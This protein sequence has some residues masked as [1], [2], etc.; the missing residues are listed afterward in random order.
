MRARR[1]AS[2]SDRA[3]F[4]RPLGG[5]FRDAFT[6]LA[7]QPARLSVL[8]VSPYPICP[9]VHGGA[10]FMYQTVRELARLCDLNLIVLLDHAR[11]REAHKKLDSMCASTQ[12]IVRMEGRQKAFGSMEPHAVRE[13]RNPDLAL[14][15]HR[16]I[17]TKQIDVVQAHGLRNVHLYEGEEW[18]D[19][20]EAV[21][22]LTKKFLCLNEVYPK[23][24]SIPKR[25]IGENI[26]HLP[27][28]KTHLRRG[29]Q[30]LASSGR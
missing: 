20:R 10:V 2:I 14:L 27:T 9:P 24:F 17:L 25:F 1:L 4:R 3:A 22:D 5:H 11:E 29:L 28:V 23:G 19:V 18:I 30:R 16:Q 26:I 21:G 13:F 15:I 12:Y 7:P 8:F 6:E